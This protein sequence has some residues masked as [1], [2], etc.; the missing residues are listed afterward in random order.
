M[1]KRGAKVEPTDIT[2]QGEEGFLKM[3]TN[4]GLDDK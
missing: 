1:N 3:R 2:E 4:E